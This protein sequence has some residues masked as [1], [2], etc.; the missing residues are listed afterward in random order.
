[1]ATRPTLKNGSKGD[2]VKELQQMLVKLGY[3]L[4][5]DGDFG[6]NTTRV[7]KQFQT[8]SKL[9][10]DGIVGAKTWAALD[11]AIAKLNKPASST[12]NTSST[13]K[14]KYN[15][16]NVPMKC[17]MTQSTCYKGTST[18]AVKGVLWHS[19]GANNPNL[20]RYVQPDDDAKDREALLK[21]IGVNTAKNDWNHITRRAG[22]N[23]WIGKLAN[24]TVTTIQTMPW[25]Y[26]P[27]GCGSGLKGSCNNGWIQ[28]EICEDGLNDKSYFDKV[29]EEGCQIT[30]YLCKLYNINPKGTV[31]HNGVKVPTILCH[32]DSHTLK[33]GSGHADVYPWFDK[34]GKT[35][36]DV[37]NRVAELLN[38]SPAPDPEPTPEPISYKIRVNTDRLNY[39]EGPGATYPIKGVLLKGEVYTIVEEKDGWGKLKS[40]AGWISLKYTEKV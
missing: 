21:K 33:L 14:M 28:F 23:C 6:S 24:G 12:T 26:K 30:A 34:F 18:M 16:T 10:S 13:A 27:W 11:A 2:Y 38:P 5:V 4:K 31:T 8:K 3:S 9:T 1:M 39:R 25:N 15:Y 20:K 22:L 17:M 37:R 32:K 36:D 29:F 40:G 19:T 35:M 7:V